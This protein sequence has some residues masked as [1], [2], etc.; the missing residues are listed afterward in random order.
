MVLEA[1][2]VEDVS[3]L[4]G[5]GTAR[6]VRG[7]CVYVGGVARVLLRAYETHKFKNVF[8]LF[9]VYLFACMNVGLMCV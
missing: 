6:Q 9:G 3:F 7:F 5:M 1:P 8:I 4:P 2:S